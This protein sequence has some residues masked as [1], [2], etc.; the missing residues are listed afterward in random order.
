M[1]DKIG[2]ALIKSQ[3][4]ILKYGLCYGIPLLFINVLPFPWL[5]IMAS[6]LFYIPYTLKYVYAKSNNI[7]L[8]RIPHWD[9]DKINEIISKEVL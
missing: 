9:F 1:G 8:L 3:E 7:R 4:V 2:A 5:I 6:L